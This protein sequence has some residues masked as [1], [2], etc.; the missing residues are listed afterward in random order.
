MSTFR[1]RQMMVAA[2]SE[3][4]NGLLKGTF[5][6]SGQSFVNFSR[7][8]LQYKS[9]KNPYWKFAD[10]QWLVIGASTAADTPNYE[11]A[12]RDLFGWGTSGYYNG[13]TYYQPWHIGNT[14][15]QYY[16]GNLTG[17][18]DWGYNAISNGG[19][20]ENSG[21]RLLTKDEWYYLFFLRITP[22]DIR[23]A[24]AQV[25]G[26]KGMLILPDDWSSESYT[27]NNVNTTSASTSTNVISEQAF[28]SIEKLGV[29]FLPTAGSQTTGAVYQVNSTGNYWTSTQNSSKKGNTFG[30][31][32]TVFSFSTALKYAGRAVRLVKNKQ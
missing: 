31:S 20:Q 11:F 1:R 9:S 12:D 19:N 18:A 2:Q 28:L 32:D 15:T 29:V 30:F 7:G 22:S 21:W 3:D 10:Q 8:N 16:S 26:V 24:K 25:N 4:D 13:Y 27:L 17:T 5:R 14:D 23:Y 6:V